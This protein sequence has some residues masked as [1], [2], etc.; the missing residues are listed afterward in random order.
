MCR[1]EGLKKPHLSIYWGCKQHVLNIS[2]HCS[3]LVVHCRASCVID[4]WVKWD[5][6][7]IVTWWHETP[8]YLSELVYLFANCGIS[9]SLYKPHRLLKTLKRSTTMYVKNL[10]GVICILQPSLRFFLIMLI[11]L[12]WIADDLDLK[13]ILSSFHIILKSKVTLLFFDTMPKC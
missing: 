7:N 11:I 4:K 9:C 5:N 10:F 13:H 12:T 1:H 8:L 2:L 3:F 6:W